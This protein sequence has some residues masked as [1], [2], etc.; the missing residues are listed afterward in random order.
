MRRIILISL[1]LIASVA[2]ASAQR[3]MEWRLNRWEQKTAITF[4][5][6][7]LFDYNCNEGIR[8]GAGLAVYPAIGNLNGPDSTSMLRIAGSAAYGLTDRAFKYNAGINYSNVSPF[9]SLYGIRFFHNNIRLGD[10]HF[11][12][13]S[14][15]DFPENAHYLSHRQVG[16]QG[17]SF[18]MGSLNPFHKNI[19][20]VLNFTRQS[21]QYLFDL[22]LIPGTTSGHQKFDL[23]SI[24]LDLYGLHW[25]AFIEGGNYRPHGA[26][27]SESRTY[28]RIIAQYDNTRHF[29]LLGSKFN[30]FFQAGLTSGTSTPLSRMFDLGGTQSSYYYFLHSFHTVPPEKFL[31]NNFAQLDLTYTFGR[32]VWKRRFSQPLPFVE[33]NSMWGSSY[34]ESMSYGRYHDIHVHDIYNDRPITQSEFHPIIFTDAPA[35]GGVIVYESPNKGLFEASLGI[36]QLIHLGWFDFGGAVSYQ[37]TPMS[38]SYHL[39]DP[40]DRFAFSVVGTFIFNQR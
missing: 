1:F 18:H 23:T 24:S 19:S 25:T 5:P 6:N 29:P 13:Y 20:F 28:A 27:S 39:S 32:S 12:P 10:R 17:L 37:L 2:S 22:N 7:T 31:A 16:I 15:I 11:K 34:A 26:L 14:I 36:R 21:Q 30:T 38:A 35:S 4:L 8:L 3:L 33:L 40:S 9:I